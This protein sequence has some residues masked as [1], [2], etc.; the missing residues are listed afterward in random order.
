M[1][2]PATIAV[3]LLLLLLIGGILSSCNSSLEPLEE[4]SFIK[5]EITQ[6]D[7]SEFYNS[8]LVEE[9]TGVQ[10]PSEPDGKKIWFRLTDE[11]EIFI[12]RSG[13]SLKETNVEALQTGQQ[14]AGWADGPVADSYP[15]QGSAKRI[16]VLQ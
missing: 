12:R 5:G 3:I 4:E 14:V 15:Q 7:K 8:I 11:S 10:E 6:I 9:N 1:L 16:V 13:G 2:R